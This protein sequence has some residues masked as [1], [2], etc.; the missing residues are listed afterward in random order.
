MK[1]KIYFL[2]IGKNAGTQIMHLCRQL[3]KFDFEFVRKNHRTRK[4]D[5]PNNCKYFFSIRNPITRFVSGFYSRKR[6]GAPKN[7]I[8]WNI[9]EKYAF[10]Q[11]KHANDLA[12]SLFRKD[13]I[14]EKAAIAVNSI[15]H[16][17]MHQVD[18]FEKT[19]ISFT[20]PL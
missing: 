19:E 2:H 16:L 1:Q 9:H 7:Y 20:T 11:F 13:K 4:I 3:E 5:L 15:N 18:Y 12:E 14:G 10:T 17:A 8:E 6:K